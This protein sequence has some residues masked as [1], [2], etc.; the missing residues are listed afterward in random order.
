[1]YAVT[2]ALGMI[3]LFTWASPDTA[4][5][6][7][8]FDLR[9]G[10]T[11]THDTDATL[12]IGPAAGIP[13]ISASGPLELKASPTLGFGGGYWLGS[14][15]WLGFAVDLSL[16]TPNE[17]ASGDNLKLIVFPISGL[18]MLRF[19]LLKSTTYPRGRL[20]PY[21]GVG[22]GA[23][24]TNAK[25]KLKKSG[26][27]K[28]FAD[29]TVAAGLDVRAGI[30]FHVLSADSDPFKDGQVGAM[31]V[32]LEYRFTHFDPPE[33]KEKIVGVPFKLE[34]D[35]LNTHHIALGL[36]VHF[37]PPRHAYR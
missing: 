26:A 25:I 9:F 36:R 29:T 35:Q 27:P 6:E 13:E 2:L 15:P 3:F 33:F 19:P 16:F 14:V 32:F 21:A 24:V 20:Q 28:N 22:P 5:A 34:L 10:A 8:F 7:A 11:V 17:D 31:A 1:M 23:F 18:L 30:N 4:R 12:K 37:M